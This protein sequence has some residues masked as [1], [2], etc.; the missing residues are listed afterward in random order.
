MMLLMGCS[1]GASD[2][3]DPPSP[4]TT[5]L[6]SASLAPW[7]LPTDVANR[8]AEAG[9]DLGPMGMAEHYHPQLQIVV[10]GVPVPIPAGIGIDPPTGSMSGLHTHS[11]D[12]VLHVE[13]DTAGEIF[14][15]VQL[16]TEWGSG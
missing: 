4:N 10:N 11:S 2:Q 15:L 14:T 8:V 1:D 6:D 13:A 5:E 16:F 3:A 9:L 7:P 12:G